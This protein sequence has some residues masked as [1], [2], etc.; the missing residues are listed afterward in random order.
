MC[1]YEPESTLPRTKNP[2]FYKDA[3]VLMRK[4]K[5]ET[6]EAND[7]A[8][9]CNKL[10]VMLQLDGKFQNLT[11][12]QQQ[13]GLRVF[14]GTEKITCSSLTKHTETKAYGTWKEGC[15]AFSIMQDKYPQDIANAQN[16]NN[17]FVK[18]V[19]QLKPT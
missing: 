3:T 1:I 2:I 16:A 10:G 4:N 8:E 9:A 14:N 15:E 6:A 18:G 19:N 5:L 12:A 7:V 13:T 17:M 11:L